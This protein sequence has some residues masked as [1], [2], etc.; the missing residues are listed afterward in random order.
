MSNNTENSQRDNPLGNRFKQYQAKK[1][2]LQRKETLLWLGVIVALA[3]IIPAFAFKDGLIFASGIVIMLF[4]I[5][6]TISICNT[7]K[8]GK[9]TIM[10]PTKEVIDTNRQEK[11]IDYWIHLAMYIFLILICIGGGVGMIITFFL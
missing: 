4:A 9:F 3:L 11:P 8:T 6:L 2:K 7:V 1:Q 5:P 10:T